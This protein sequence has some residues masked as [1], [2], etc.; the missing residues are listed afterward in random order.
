MKQ[1]QT[2]DAGESSGAD[3]AD[4]L[5]ILSRMREDLEGEALE[6]PERML[7]LPSHGRW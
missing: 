5:G 4:L 1:S 7:V 3:K 6:V 2:E